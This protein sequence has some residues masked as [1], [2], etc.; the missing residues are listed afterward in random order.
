MR[1][2][3]QVLVSKGAEVVTVS[4]DQTVLEAAQLMN[5]KHIGAVPVVTN[6]TVVGI[7]SERDILRRVVAK[8]REPSK[9]HVRDVMT[10]PVICA[11][12]NSSLDEIRTVM[13]EK[14]IRHIPVVEDGHLEGILSIGDLNI[15]QAKDQE[16]TIQYLEQFIYRP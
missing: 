11:A 14:R 8:E 16:D 4:P 12:S 5:E 3:H 10:S 9:T 7:F 15:V 13:R 1:T 6:D 2:A